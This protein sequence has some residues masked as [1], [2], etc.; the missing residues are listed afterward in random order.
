MDTDKSFVFLMERMPA[1]L[2]VV[3]VMGSDVAMLT[4][5][6]YSF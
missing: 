5:P 3:T 4:A 6:H 1:I 2:V